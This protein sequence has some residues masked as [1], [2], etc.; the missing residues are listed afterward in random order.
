MGFYGHVPPKL[1]PSA[2][3]G[4]ILLERVHFA[5]CLKRDRHP[6]SSSCNG[7]SVLYILCMCWPLSMHQSGVMTCRQRRSRDDPNISKRLK[8]GTMSG[9]QNRC[10]CV[11]LM[12]NPD[13]PMGRLVYWSNWEV[14]NAHPGT[15]GVGV[16]DKCIIP[17]LHS[18]VSGTSPGQWLLDFAVY[19]HNNVCTACS[20]FSSFSEWTT[21]L[22]HPNSLCQSPRF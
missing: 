9:K 15:L 2:P 14:F 6:P 20:W 5:K 11:F 17:L 21:F 3:N 10:G 7:L 13:D 18:M 4:H 22:C 8:G 1:R 19:W 16:W 12:G